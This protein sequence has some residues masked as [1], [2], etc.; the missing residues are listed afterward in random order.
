MS[1]L[2]SAITALSDGIESNAGKEKYY[3]GTQF[4][5]PGLTIPN[6]AYSLPFVI[7]TKVNRREPWEYTGS[8]FF[9][10]P[11]RRTA[12]APPPSPPPSQPSGG[13]GSPW[14]TGERCGGRPSRTRRRR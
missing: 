1:L 12:S 10:P 9:N 3:V 7:T 8:P 13:G 2:G 6:T 14:R 11:V 4:S 5:R